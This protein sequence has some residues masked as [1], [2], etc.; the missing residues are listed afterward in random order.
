VA[1][2][3]GWLL[4]SVTV[5]PLCGIPD[6]QNITRCGMPVKDFLP[7]SGKLFDLRDFRCN[8]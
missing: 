6:R 2:G 1:R 4:V 7:Q 5:L 8:F 3:A